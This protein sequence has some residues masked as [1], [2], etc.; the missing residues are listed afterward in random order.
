MSERCRSGRHRD[1]ENPACS[2]VCHRRHLDGAGRGEMIDITT[3]QV[4]SIPDVARRLGRT[5]V[6][7]RRAIERGQIPARRWG[8]RIIILA[9]ELDAYLRALPRVAS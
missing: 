9:D 2:C 4:L 7:T 5:E 8:R 6:A 3:M 1:C